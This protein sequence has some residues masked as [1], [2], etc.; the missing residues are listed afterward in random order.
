MDFVKSKRT[1]KQA[2][3]A[4][5]LFFISSENMDDRRIIAPI[6]PGKNQWL[7]PKKREKNKVINEKEKKRNKAS[8]FFLFKIK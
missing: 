8:S 2:N 3:I 1:I 4:L 6:A 7:L 5:N